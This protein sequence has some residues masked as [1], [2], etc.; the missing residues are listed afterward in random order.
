MKK[1]IQNL[2]FLVVLVVA[3]YFTYQYF[4]IPWLNGNAPAESDPYAHLM[5]LPDQC[6]D[7][8]KLMLDAFYK[9]KKGEI[10]RASVNGYRKSFRECLRFAGYDDSQ[11]DEAYDKLK[12]SAGYKDY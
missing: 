1:K 2:V 12:D 3:G 10:S 5:F 9:N 4:V 7:V 6:Q 8:G 11:I